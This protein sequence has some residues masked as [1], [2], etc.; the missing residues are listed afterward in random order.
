MA[1][2]VELLRPRGP[3]ALPPAKAVDEEVWQA[4]LAKGREQS[5]RSAAAWTKA[6][7][8]VS[9][10]GLL[11]AAVMGPRL[12]PFDVVIRFVVTAGAILVMSKAFQAGQYTVAVVFGALALL[13][14]PVVLMFTFSGDWQ[15]AVVAACTIP[16][17]A[18][19]ARA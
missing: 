6:V 9:I 2:S 1:T 3:W 10:G 13:Y 12:A 17:V 11:A 4:W 15:R 8:W 16:F 19:L 14:N 18:S 7:M 5:R